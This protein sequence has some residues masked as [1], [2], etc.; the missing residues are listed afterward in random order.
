MR[1]LLLLRHAKSSWADPG[2]HDFERPLNARGN[3]AA[4]R[5]A[6]Y[7]RASG[8]DPDQILC[9]SARRTR[10]TLAHLLPVLPAAKDIR[11]LPALYE[12]DGPGYAEI[13]RKQATGSRVMLIGHNPSIEDLGLQLSSN[14]DSADRKRMA[15]KFPTCALAVFEMSASWDTLEARNAQLTGFVTPAMLT[16][17]SGT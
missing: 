14:A 17:D 2:L 3:D 16:L 1:Q 6:Q 5:M 11:I 10:E 15:Q 4:P 8:Y 13:I 12:A 7:I 9:S